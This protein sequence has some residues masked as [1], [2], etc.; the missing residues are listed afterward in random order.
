MFARRV[1]RWSSSSSNISS[2]SARAAASSPSSKSRSA[3]SPRS[4]LRSLNEPTAVPTV[5]VSDTGCDEAS[6][7]G[8]PARTGRATRTSA[9]SPL[10]SAS[11]P[12][13]SRW[14]SPACTTRSPGAPRR[15]GCRSTTSRACSCVRSAAPTSRLLAPTPACDSAS[16]SHGARR[17]RSARSRRFTIRFPVRARRPRC[18]AGSRAPSPTSSR[19]RSSPPCSRRPR[20]TG[21]GS[22]ASRP[23]TARSGSRIIQAPENAIALDALVRDIRSTAPAIGLLPWL[24]DELPAGTELDTLR[25]L[26]LRP[27][28]AGAA[29]LLIDGGVGGE[30]EDLTELE[31]AHRMLAGGAHGRREPRQRGASRRTAR[32]GQPP[33]P[34]DAGS[35]V[36]QPNAR[37]ARR[38]RG[39][40]R[41]RDEQPAD[42][43]LRSGAAPRLAARRRGAPRHGPG[44]RDPVAPTQAT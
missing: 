34:R 31:G 17:A 40:R 24:R 41:A 4:A 18:S 43:H 29:M 42:D 1:R 36:A 25:V 32:R 35:A 21:G 3:R 14:R 19:R 13:S 27:A 16:G 37:H 38:G 44:D 22:S 8:T 28:G 15:S 26:P 30:C 6:R 5:S 33:D 11:R 39:R 20:Q 7:P 9:P 23:G 12:N 10:P 2:H